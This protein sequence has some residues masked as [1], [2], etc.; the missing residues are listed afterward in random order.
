MIKLDEFLPALVKALPKSEIKL[1]MVWLE[2]EHARVQ[3][4]ALSSQL[5]EEARPVITRTLR[6]LIR[7][8]DRHSHQEGI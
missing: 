2:D 6:Q 8:E 7:N 4:S 1:G 5:Q 3:V